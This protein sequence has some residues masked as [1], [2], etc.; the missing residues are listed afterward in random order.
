M[1]AYFTNDKEEPTELERVIERFKKEF[2]EDFKYGKND[3]TEMTLKIPSLKA[4]WSEIRAIHKAKQEQLEDKLKDYIF[5]G[6]DVV[7]KQQEAAGKPCT[8]QGAENMIKS[9]KE[10]KNIEKRVKNLKNLNIFLEDLNKSSQGIDWT[11]KNSLTSISA[12][13]RDFE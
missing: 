2:I 7:K 5:I 4:K 3:I 13:E 10:Y 11:I 9:S 12:D 8:K 6:V 1:K